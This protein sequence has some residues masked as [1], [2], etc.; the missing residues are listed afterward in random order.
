MYEVR[1]T[2]KAL[3]TLEK[4]EKGKKGMIVAW[5]EKNLVGCDDPRR[6]GMPLKAGHKGEWRY[7]KGDYRII[8]DISDNEVLIL[9]LHIGDRKN[10]YQ[11]R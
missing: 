6:Y 10:V 8:C 1:Y 5:I 4:M 11:I 3:K 9:V 2:K 7:R